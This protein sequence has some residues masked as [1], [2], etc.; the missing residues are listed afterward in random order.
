MTAAP[1]SLA[2]ALRRFDDERLT[3]LLRARPDLAVPVPRGIGPLA[4]R[5]AAPSSVQRAVGALTR[6]ELILLEALV[7]LPDPADPAALASAVGST[8][9]ET[10]PL[11][12]RLRTLA[13][14]WGST[15]VRAVRAARE[16]LR[17]PAGLAPEAD[18]DPS[19][20]EADRRV[21][22]APV[23]LAPL[24]ERLAW[25][26]SRVDAA[27][28]SSAARLLT[29]AGL[30]VRRGDALLMP[31]PVQLAL[32]GG[33]VRPSLPTERPRPL[34]PEIHE[35]VPGARDA[36]GAEAALEAVRI[37]D[38]IGAWDE[39]PPAV[40]R[41]GGIPQ[42]DLRRLAQRADADPAVLA[43]VVQ[44]A[45][46]AGLV[47][48]DGAS[49]LPSADWDAAAARAVEERWAELALSWARSRHIASLAGT[50]DATGAAR[51][52]LGG[53][54][55]RDGVRAHRRTLLEALRASCG[56]HAAEESLVDL[57]GWS[58]PLAASA[59][60]REETRALLIE[61]AALGLVLDGALTGLGRALVDALD[62]DLP[63]A[64]AHLAAALRTVAPP[65]VDEVLLDADLTATIPGRP[66]ERL[67][68]L[69]DWTEVVS[70]GGAL[71]L[72]FTAA[73]VRRAMGAG[74][75]GD[76]LLALLREASRSGVPQALEYL[77]RDESR[78]HG[79]VR[80]G[81]AAS[82]L[83]A[84][85]HVLTLFQGS[86]HAE[87]LA[88]QRLA[89]TVAVTTSEPGLVLQMVRRSGLS[90][91]AVGPDGQ[92]AADGA[93]R[94][95]EARAGL[96]GAPVEPD[97]ETV[98]GPELRLSPSEAVAR[99]RAAE[100]SA[101]EDPSVTDRLLEAIAGGTTLRLG[102]VDG[103]GGILAREAVP[104]SLD[105]GRLRARDTRGTE[106]FTVLVHRVTL[107]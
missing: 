1:R 101:S 36:Q 26:P 53:A 29:A 57:L 18:D 30:L 70:R 20:A 86:P 14:A 90:G 35:R 40:L 10:A 71:T 61:G 37:L 104:I 3:E 79:Q 63:A 21:R 73:T 68:K 8:E 41:R 78:R 55:S 49:W 102:I 94:R 51:A 105:G 5:A 87:P 28:G 95:A 6:P 54:L 62:E 16:V 67:L 64:D 19:H 89:P 39:D 80:I 99:I 15:E 75:D 92:V 74:H 84:E 107:G 13:L 22:E 47:G 83:T 76:R 12:E 44:T 17:T 106:E 60:L 34:G 7:A 2:D 69:Q 91:L 100:R 45:W 23:E 56:V 4:A 96:G 46:A 66:A 98:A 93:D 77:L 27:E 82:W 58:F 42:R 48:H 81:R 43:T 85:E 11:L 59:H 72:R 88:L 33:R 103:R 38:T 65:A 97:I 24:L 50:A 9:R 52:L 25:G 31:R 32:R